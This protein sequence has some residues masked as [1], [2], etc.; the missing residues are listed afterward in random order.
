M[1]QCGHWHATADEERLCH[2]KGRWAQKRGLGSLVQCLGF[3]V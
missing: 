3:R 2:G 1:S